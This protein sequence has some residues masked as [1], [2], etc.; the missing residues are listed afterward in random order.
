MNV[1]LTFILIMLI[2]YCIWYNVSIYNENM[3][4]ISDVDNQKYL[5][6]GGKNKSEYFLKESA[7]MLAEINR[8]VNI[9]IDYLYDKYKYDDSMNYLINHLKRNYSV[10]KISEAA[11]DSKHTTYTVNK[12]EMHICLRTRDVNEK[13]YD[14]NLLMYVIIHELAH[15]ANYD[16]NKKPII[17]HGIEFKKIFRLLVIESINIGIYKYIDYRKTPAEYCGLNLYTQIAA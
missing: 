9:L 7:N 4:V 6:R 12:R 13:L 8:R 5:I 15:M 17:G 11:T 1:L 2:S 10:D 14:I 3:Y 16:T